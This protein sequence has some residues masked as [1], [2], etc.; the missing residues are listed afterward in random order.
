MTRRFNT[1]GLC[2][3]GQ[4]YMVP[5]IPRLPDAPRLIEQGSFFVVH[6][7]RQTGKSTTLRA[8]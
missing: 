2:I 6:A 5:P 1:T 7:P 3:E 4:H 8:I